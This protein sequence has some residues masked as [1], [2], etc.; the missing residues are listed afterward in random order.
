MRHA[1]SPRCGASHDASEQP[2][3]ATRMMS[4][5]RRIRVMYSPSA[6]VPARPLLV[7]AALLTIVALSKFSSGHRSRRCD[8]AGSIAGQQGQFHSRLSSLFRVSVHSIGSR[9]RHKRSLAAACRG[10]YDRLARFLVEPKTLA[11]PSNEELVALAVDGDDDAI[12]QLA[13]RHRAA[14][15]A[16]IYRMVHHRGGDHRELTDIALNKAILRFKTFKPGSLYRSWLIAIARNTAIDWIRHSGLA[17][18]HEERVRQRETVALA[19]LAGLRELARDVVRRSE[20]WVK[21]H[22]GTERARTLHQGALMRLRGIDYQRIANE[23]DYHSSEAARQVIR[24][25]IELAA[26]QSPEAM[27]QACAIQADY[28]SIAACLNRKILFLNV[29]DV[30]VVRI[31]QEKLHG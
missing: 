22:L 20:E 4:L 23:L 14:V 25:G 5:G 24:S 12:A 17:Q 15:S 3:D 21:T 11:E 30:E 9:L 1:V 8:A 2:A 13:R 19:R 6:G 27:A 10:G 7:R 16:L 31:R 26:V 28:G 18:R 29:L